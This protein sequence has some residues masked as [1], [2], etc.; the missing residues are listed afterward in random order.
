MTCFP[1]AGPLGLDPAAAELGKVPGNC[2]P[3]NV[4]EKVFAVA[5]Q[6]AFVVAVALVGPE[7]AA[8]AA[9]EKFGALKPYLQWMTMT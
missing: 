5:E 2:V 9:A 1:A 6:T 3:Q 8:V 7:A 4:A